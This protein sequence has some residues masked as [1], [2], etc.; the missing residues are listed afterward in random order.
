M[1][2]TPDDPNILNERGPWVLSKKL[3]V[4][5]CSSRI[6]F[7]N[8]HPKSCAHAKH[9]LKVVLRV[10]RGDDTV[11]DEKGRKRQVNTNTN[12]SLPRAESFLNSVRY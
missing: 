4:P 8:Q 12:S 1:L 5:D 11:V 2:E 7:T 6:H 10:Q 3:E 9:S